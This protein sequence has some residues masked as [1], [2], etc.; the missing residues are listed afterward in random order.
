MSYLKKSFAARDSFVAVAVAVAGVVAAVGGLC[1]IYWRDRI[2][3]F[4]E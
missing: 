3:K 4:H 1:A 2:L